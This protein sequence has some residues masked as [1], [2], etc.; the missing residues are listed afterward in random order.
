[1]CCLFG[2]LDYKHNLT[3]KQQRRVVSMLAIAAEDRGTDATGIAYNSHDRLHI[4]NALS[5]HMG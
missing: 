1:M 2:M 5:R 3:Q 4:Y